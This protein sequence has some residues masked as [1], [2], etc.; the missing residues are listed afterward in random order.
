MW[1]CAPACCMRLLM[2]VRIYPS[3]FGS[4]QYIFADVW[5]SH[6]CTVQPAIG[7]RVLWYLTNILHQALYTASLTACSWISLHCPS[8]CWQGCHIGLNRNQKRL[9]RLKIIMF[10]LLKLLACASN[11]CR[12][13]RLGTGFRFH[14]WTRIQKHW[15]QWIQVDGSKGNTVVLCFKLWRCIIPYACA[16]ATN[17]FE[18]VVCHLWSGKFSTHKGLY[19]GLR[20]V[21][22]HYKVVWLIQVAFPKCLPQENVNNA[23]DGRHLDDQSVFVHHIL[24]NRFAN[25]L[26][27]FST[28]KFCCLTLSEFCSGRRCPFFQKFFV[29]IDLCESLMWFSRRFLVR[30]SA[31][32]SFN[33]TGKPSFS[34]S[35]YEPVDFRQNKSL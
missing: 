2:T 8:G 14:Y 31:L 26:G 33:T 27:G 30:W 12:S 19:L 18:Y 21:A 13:W 9:W 25:T 23:I 1:I 17:S 22:R 15:S 29:S 3:V 6:D 16:A 4:L 34:G 10:C 5:L 35:V 32:K 11:I 20:S 24:G 28:I 7:L